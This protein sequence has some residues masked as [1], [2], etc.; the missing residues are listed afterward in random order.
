[1]ESRKNFNLGSPSSNGPIRYAYLGKEV[2]DFLG[3][4]SINQQTEEYVYHCKLEIRK[5]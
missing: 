3:L 4:Q 1:M 5:K 2:M